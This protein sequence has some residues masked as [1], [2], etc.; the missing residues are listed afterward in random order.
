MVDDPLQ[1]I[2]QVL[3]IMG[4]APVY[5]PAW[6]KYTQ[7]NYRTTKH[8]RTRCSVTSFT[9]IFDNAGINHNLFTGE[10]AE[11][12]EFSVKRDLNFVWNLVEKMMN[13][14]NL[15]INNLFNF[16]GYQASLNM[17]PVSPYNEA[18]KLLLY[19]QN[20]TLGVGILNYVVAAGTKQIDINSTLDL[21]LK[22]I[23]KVH[24]IIYGFGRTKEVRD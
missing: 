5:L 7:Y 12:V 14:Y 20:A 23:C 8:Q 19:R 3:W 17:L 4:E 18:E 9:S 2:W 16:R 24:P 21:E 22:A 1:K 10:R 15:T 6:V 11:A 13:F